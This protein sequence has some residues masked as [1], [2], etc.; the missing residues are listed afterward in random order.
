[1]IDFINAMLGLDK[2]DVDFE[3]NV[4]L[5][6]DQLDSYKYWDSSLNAKTNFFGYISDRRKIEELF[7]D[8]T[9]L[10]STS[11][12][13]TLGLHVIEGIRNGVITIT[14]NESYSTEVYGENILKYELFNHD[15]LIKTIMMLINYKE[16]Y[17]HRI[18]YAQSDIKRIEMCKYESV[19][20][21]FDKIVNV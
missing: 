2:K 11:I 18:L 12:I 15:S 19:V 17:D 9:I 21:I 13:E 8:N 5:T 3:I 4:T 1:M 14:P 16:S 10:I 6:R 20:E 7:C